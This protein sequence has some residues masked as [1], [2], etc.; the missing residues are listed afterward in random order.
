MLLILV[1]AMGGDNAPEAVVNGC[2]EAISELD[3]FEVQLIGDSDRI[4]QII[5]RRQFDNSRM[6]I[7]H[8]GEVITNDD[9]PSR[10]IKSKKDSSMVVGFKL[11]K[12]KKGNV[13]LSAG[14]TGALM[15]G[16]LLLLGRIEGVDRPALPTFLPTKNGGTLLIDSGINTV[17]KPVN[18]LQFGIMGS[19]YMKEVHKVVSPKVGLI[20]NGTE[21]K[22][23]TD[24]IKQAYP[25]LA[26]SNV[27]FVGN[28]E[29]R[30]LL[31]GDINVAVCDGFVGNVVLKLLEGS[32]TFFLGILK[33]SFTKNIMTKLAAL[34]VK[35]HLKK[36]MKSFDY[37]EIGG[38]PIL[39]VDGI[40]FKSHGS[41]NAKAVKNAIL[42]AHRFTKTTVVQQIRD[43]FKNM[44]VEDIE[45]SE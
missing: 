4:R 22:K 31:I 39:G 32:V 33:E 13:F 27:N 38:T 9:S 43:E 28:V 35:G 2:I 41:S 25:M 21:E 16:A 40:V 37:E 14:N 26:N 29:A 23:G 3:G 15:A 19:I 24:V 44:E 5:G 1:D 8:A 45:Q 11:L 42:T 36:Q 18:Y 34:V 7:I 20:N 6:K 30:Q 17:C 12:E 10:A